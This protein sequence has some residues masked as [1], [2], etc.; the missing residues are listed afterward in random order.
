MS[1]VAGADTAVFAPVRRTLS[2]GTLAS[3]KHHSHLSRSR[4]RHRRCGSCGEPAS[5]QVRH[6]DPGVDRPRRARQPRRAGWGRPFVVH[7]A[8]P[9]MGVF[10]HRRADVAHTLR[11]VGPQR[12]ILSS[13]DAVHRLF[14]TCGRLGTSIRPSCP[15]DCGSECGQHDLAWRRVMW[16]QIACC[17]IRLVNSVTGL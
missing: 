16:R 8:V 10:T 15:Q 1:F 13:C 12:R 2:S 11:A 17:L 14:H 3:S 5:V 4:H 9:R 7:I 6:H